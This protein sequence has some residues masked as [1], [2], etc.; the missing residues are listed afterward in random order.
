MATGFCKTVLRDG[1]GRDLPGKGDKVSIAY[2][3]YLRDVNNED[4]EK[5]TE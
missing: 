1:N 3:G 2:T 5:G 4:F